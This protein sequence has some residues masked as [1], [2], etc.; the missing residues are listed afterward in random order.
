VPIACGLCL[1]R[2]WP[3]KHTVGADRPVNLA[4]AR[5]VITGVALSRRTF[6]RGSAVAVGFGLASPT[7]VLA[8]S[9]N[10]RDPNPIPGGTAFLAPQDPKIFHANFPAFGQE[11]ST[12]TDFNGLLGAAEIQGGG[13]GTDLVYDADRRFMRGTYIAVDGRPCSGPEWFPTTPSRL[14]CNTAPPDSR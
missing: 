10:K 5:C 3:A 7:V 4:G 14:I 13:I 11:V 9:A 2:G 1:V 12:I 8:D 6:L